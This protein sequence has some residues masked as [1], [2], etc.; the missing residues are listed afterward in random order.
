MNAVSKGEQGKDVQVARNAL[1]P[2]G[3]PIVLW[4]ER[5]LAGFVK[6]RLT[7]E[8][9]K[10]LSAVSLDVKAKAAA[11][12]A[13]KGQ[14]NFTEEGEHA[15]KPAKDVKE[16]KMQEFFVGPLSNHEMVLKRAIIEAIKGV[17]VIP[18]RLGS[19]VNMDKNVKAAWE[20]AKI[21]WKSQDV[22]ATLAY[23]VEFCMKDEVYVS[24][25]PCVQFT[26][27]FA[28][29]AGVKR[30]ATQNQVM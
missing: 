20:T 9:S 24:R 7:P 3:F 2:K 21:A 19:L 4:I 12:P 18:L 30:K 5:R 22:E 29:Q 14:E 28:K 6:T 17:E 11:R 25:E 10:E 16:E 26:K 27:E 23:W 8:G 15:G 1:L 13:R